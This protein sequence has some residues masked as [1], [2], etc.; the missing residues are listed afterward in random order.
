M[1]HMTATHH[2]PE[3]VWRPLVVVLLVVPRAPLH[4]EGVEGAE[5][6]QVEDDEDDGAHRHQDRQEP[7]QVA[8]CRQ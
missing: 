1:S 2:P 3:Y 8:G 4:D 5:L 7:H 6:E